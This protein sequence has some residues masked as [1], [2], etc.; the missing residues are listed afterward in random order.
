MTFDFRLRSRQGKKKGDTN[1]SNALIYAL[2]K[3]YFLCRGS[4]E[5]VNL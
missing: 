2:F 3:H 1:R 4:D 5:T